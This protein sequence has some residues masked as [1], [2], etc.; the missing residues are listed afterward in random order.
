MKPPWGD[1]DILKEIRERQERERLEREEAEAAFPLVDTEEQAIHDVAVYD[2]LRVAEVTSP[3]WW[4]MF[5]VYRHSALPPELTQVL[6]AVEQ[7]LHGRLVRVVADAREHTPHGRAVQ[8]G[9]F[10]LYPGAR[11]GIDADLLDEREQMTG[12]QL[13][14]LEARYEPRLPPC[15]LDGSRA[16]PP[17]IFLEFHRAPRCRKITG[18]ARKKWPPDTQSLWLP[19][20]EPPPKEETASEPT[21]RKDRR[22]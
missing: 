2:V 3:G 9:L 5:G 11:L 21:P 20:M 7:H 17:A 12:W 10:R 19:G 6:S 4:R 16:P 1:R 8:T 18:T 14:C 13:T 15:R 22:K